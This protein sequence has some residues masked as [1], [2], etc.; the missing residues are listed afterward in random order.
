MRHVRYFEAK[1]GHGIVASY[2]I[3]KRYRWPCISSGICEYIRSRRNVF[4]LFRDINVA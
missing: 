3:F 2:V 1:L 4:I